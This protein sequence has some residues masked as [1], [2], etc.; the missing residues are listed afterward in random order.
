MRSAALRLALPTLLLF[1]PAL[2]SA[3]DGDAAE[4]LFRA[5][6]ERLTKAKSLTIGFSSETGEG[7]DKAVKLKGTLALADGDRC[8][9]EAEGKVDRDDIKV[10]LVSDGKQVRLIRTR[11][12]APEAKRDSP[13]RKN[14]GAALARAISR[15]GVFLGLEGTALDPQRKGEVELDKLFPVSDLKL[16]GKEKVGGREAQILTYKVTV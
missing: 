7:G 13:T 15:T 8:R 14:F 1:T 5:M 9:L 2:A 4:K 10:T 6:E 3:Q 11:G 12:G 16:G